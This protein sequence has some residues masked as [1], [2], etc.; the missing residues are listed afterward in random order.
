[1]IRKNRKLNIGKYRK[2]NKKRTNKYIIHKKKNES[3]IDKRRNNH[4]R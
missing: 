2:I 1:M 3:K 4:R